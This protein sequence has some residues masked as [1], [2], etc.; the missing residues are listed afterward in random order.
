[1][2]E[3]KLSFVVA[4]YPRNSDIIFRECTRRYNGS[5]PVLEDELL[6]A[7]KKM[8]EGKGKSYTLVIEVRGNTTKE[9]Q[10]IKKRRDSIY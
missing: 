8:G 7:I 1:M 6:G 9:I 2:K 4:S 5:R 3:K 10:D